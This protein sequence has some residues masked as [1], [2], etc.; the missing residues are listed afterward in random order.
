[1]RRAISLVLLVLALGGA[2]ALAAWGMREP[3]GAT[4]TYH[5]VV[6]GPQGPLLDGTP[7]VPDATALAALL[8]AA[9]A[10]GIAVDLVEYPGMGTYVRAIAGIEARG[11]SGWIYEVQREGSWRSGD[12]SAAYYGLQKGDSIRWSWTDG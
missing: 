12:R 11:T 10:E 3:A 1:M 8:A 2:G 4:D 5:V 6:L 9:A 7:S